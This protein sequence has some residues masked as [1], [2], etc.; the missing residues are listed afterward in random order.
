MTDRLLRLPV[1]TF[2]AAQLWGTIAA[3]TLAPLFFGS[4]DQLWVA[5]WAIVLSATTFCGVATPLGR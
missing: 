4:V 3:L 2:R 1:E 5:I